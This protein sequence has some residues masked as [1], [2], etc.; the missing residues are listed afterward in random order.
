MTKTYQIKMICC[1]CKIQYGS[2]PGGFKP[3]LESHGYC[4][5]CFELEMV[6][7][8]EWKDD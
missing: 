4:L 1:V 8:K 6:K 5:D 7:I 2:K 3:G